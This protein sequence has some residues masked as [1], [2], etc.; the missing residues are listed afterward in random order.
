MLHTPDP[1]L[2]V[3][4]C[5][6]SLP[7]WTHQSVSPSVCPPSLPPSQHGP[8]S[9]SVH[10]CALPPSLPAWTH[11]SVSPSVCPP[12]LPPSMD[13]PVSQSIC[14]PSLP[15]SQHGPTIVCCEGCRVKREGVVG[16]RAMLFFCVS[17][18]VCIVLLVAMSM[19]VGMATHKLYSGTCHPPLH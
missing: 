14:V 19:Q 2:S 11:Q 12:S 4:L 6:P 17:P 8:T 7:V 16:K 1:H 15:P 18:W 5:A 10:L 9:Q 3:Y 13:P